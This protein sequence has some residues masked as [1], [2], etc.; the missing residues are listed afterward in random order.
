LTDGSNWASRDLGTEYNLLF[1]DQ[2]NTDNITPRPRFEMMQ[3]LLFQ[4][5][6]IEAILIA[7]ERRRRWRKL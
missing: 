3:R 7:L 4:F 2:L 6:T 5:F 1:H